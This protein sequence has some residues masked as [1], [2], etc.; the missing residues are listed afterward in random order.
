MDAL[1]A[2]GGEQGHDVIARREQRHFRSHGLDDPGAFVPE[3]ARRVA[4]RIVA[5]RGVEIRVADAAGREP[6]EHL[7]GLGLGQLQLLYGERMPELLE[8]RGADLH[9]APFCERWR[10]AIVR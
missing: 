5:G 9:V 3:D 7:A 6:D 8:H 1:S 2:L 10:F 4:A